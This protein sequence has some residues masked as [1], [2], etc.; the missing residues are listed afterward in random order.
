M[1]PNQLN[2]KLT[3]LTYLEQIYLLDFKYTRREVIKHKIY[4][5]PLSAVDQGAEGVNV[6]FAM[7]RRLP[8]RQPRRRNP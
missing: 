4:I 1:W 2:H 7:P 6:K 5:Y 3:C 8:R